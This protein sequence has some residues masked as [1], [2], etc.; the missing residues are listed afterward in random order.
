M[1]TPQ[2]ILSMSYAFVGSTTD[3]QNDQ[4]TSH[5]FKSKTIR[6]FHKVAE[7]FLNLWDVTRIQRVPQEFIG[8]PDE[9]K[10]FLCIHKLIDLWIFPFY[11]SW[12]YQKLRSFL[13]FSKAI[14]QWQWEWRVSFGE[15]NT[16]YSQKR[17]GIGNNIII[18]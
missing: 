13:I 15:N 18:V 14:R 6:L 17:A 5:F 16:Q 4:W 7:S 10:N 12:K 9:S 8:S 11:F 3:F 1:N 2:V